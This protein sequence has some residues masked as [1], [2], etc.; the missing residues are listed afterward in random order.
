[1]NE[2]NTVATADVETYLEFIRNNDEA[3]SVA[4]LQEFFKDDEGLKAFV[5]TVMVA[6]QS[7]G[8]AA[9]DAHNEAE[10]NEAESTEV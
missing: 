6:A 9:V 4:Y 2:A 5:D 8:Q 3:G 7:E 1:M 10:L